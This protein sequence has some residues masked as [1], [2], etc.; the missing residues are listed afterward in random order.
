MTASASGG[1]LSPRHHHGTME[2]DNPCNLAKH[3]LAY[4]AELGSPS[5]GK[6]AV[7]SEKDLAYSSAVEQGRRDLARLKTLADIIAAQAMETKR[8]VEMA[9]AVSRAD[10]NFSPRVGREYWLAE[11]GSEGRT[12][13]C[14]LGPDEWAG[15]VPDGYRYL[16][17]VRQ[18]PTGLWESVDP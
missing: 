12:I 7:K 15:G 5:F 4:P 14:H 18:L 2:D 16:G 9:E 8:Q 10:C 1:K 11:V 3:S 6:P 13:L 17:K